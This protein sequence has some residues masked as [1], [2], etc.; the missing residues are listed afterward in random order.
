MFECKYVGGS[1][2]RKRMSPRAMDKPGYGVGQGVMEWAEETR[3]GSP[4]QET[5]EDEGEEDEDEDEDASTKPL[6]P[7]KRT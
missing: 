4:G 7:G 6:E 5:V 2:K 1:W 3:G